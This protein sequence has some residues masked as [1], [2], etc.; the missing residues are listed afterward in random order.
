MIGQKSFGT[1]D[2]EGKIL[3]TVQ[4][5]DLWDGTTEN[6]KSLPSGVYII[7]GKKGKQTITILR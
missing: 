3:R 1:L 5:G 2:F 4:E 6:G 7:V